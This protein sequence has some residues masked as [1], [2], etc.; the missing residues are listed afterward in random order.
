[1]SLKLKCHKHWHVK[2]TKIQLK[3][4]ATKTLII[5]KL[6]CYWTWN[7]TKTEMSLKINK[8]KHHHISLSK[9]WLH[10]L[11]FLQKQGC[12]KPWWDQARLSS[13]VNKQVDLPPSPPHPLW[14]LS[15]ACPH[16][17]PEPLSLFL[18]CECA[19]VVKLNWEQSWAMS[20]QFYSSCKAHFVIVLGE[21]VMAITPYMGQCN[22]LCIAQL[23][24]VACPNTWLPKTKHDKTFAK[25]GKLSPS[26]H[27]P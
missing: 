19:P 5:L 3:L 25:L 13:L 16:F 24:I 12:Q 7:V 8:E 2:K 20:Q 1:M 10:K 18:P 26:N 27:G 9:Q 14:F 15:A 11:E 4:N 17:P 21:K 23:S 6:I 22:M